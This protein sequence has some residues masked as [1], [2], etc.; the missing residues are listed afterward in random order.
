MHPCGRVSRHVLP[1]WV[2][3]CSIAAAQPVQPP[4]PPDDLRSELAAKIAD[5]IASGAVVEAVSCSVNVREHVCAADLRRG[6][7]REVLMVTRAHESATSA[8]DVSTPVVLE[9][10]PLLSRTEPILDI[11]TLGSRLLVLGPSA[12]TMYE[13]AADDWRPAS[14]RPVSTSRPWP[15]DLRGKLRVEGARYEA[16]LPGVTC[17]GTLDPLTAGCI[18]ATRPWPIAFAN[19]GIAEGGN[20]FALAGD[21]TYFTAAPLGPDAGGRWLVAAGDGRLLFLDSERRRL[22]TVAGFGSDVAAVATSCTPGTVIL[23]SPATPATGTHT[24]RLFRVAG[25]EIAEAT[26]PIVLTGRLTALWTTATG[27]AAIAVSRHP[28]TPRYEA[29]QIRVA[30]GR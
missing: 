29:F 30:C 6:E 1:F 19:E 28:T 9:M 14:S 27:D 22:D 10:R 17:S 12:L 2:L 3:A 21:G 4:E 25:R 11:S 15:R 16:F 23:A 5:A 26:P 7:A 20:A 13:K 8:M 24:L 18:D